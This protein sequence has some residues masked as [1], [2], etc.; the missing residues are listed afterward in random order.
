MLDPII[1]FFVR[2]FNAIGLGI[3]WFIGVL[4]WPFV[5]FGK[6]YNQRGWLIKG[7]VGI[8]LLVLLASYVWFVVVTQRWSGFDP[9]YAKAYTAHADLASAGEPSVV[10]ADTTGTGT[11]TESKPATGETRCEPSRIVRVTS[12]LIDFN[13]NQNNW[14]PSMLLAKMGFFG[15]PWKNTPFLDNKA[16][17]QLGVNQATRRVSIELV[18]R[19][20]RVRG[21]S[22][23]DR[24]LQEAREKLAYDED[25]WYF[26]FDPFGP[27]S[28]TQQN[29][30]RARESLL[31][32]NQEL[33]ACRSNFDART[34]N[35]LQFLDRITSDIGAT[36]D[37]LRSRMEA[38]N[39]GW[40]DPRADDRFWF[41]YGQL[42][43]YYGIL[44]ATR[45]DFAGVFKNR[46]LEQIWLRTEEQL[47]S[48]LDLQPAVISNGHEASW[49][50]PTHLATMGF[51]VL[52][53]R[54]N[55]V[56]TRDI[57]DR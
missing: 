47:R 43:A 41:A 54:S 45:A 36:S 2:I 44:T 24:N 5:A 32:F 9:D 6:W 31:T 49:I 34:D 1:N 46:N 18:D 28:T 16:A 50:M 25:S 8:A 37:I 30:R 12:D 7:P 17:F 22:G 27:R 57:L 53:I 13:V 21:T 56:E 19:L 42:Y 29:Y 52:R 26:S 40:F 3:G 48:A 35:L 39:A 55:L 38:S 15:V 10:V 51:Y 23:I 11:T 33:V 20:G 14:I 4:L